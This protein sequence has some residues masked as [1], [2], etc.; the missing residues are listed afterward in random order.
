MKNLL[1]SICSILLFS[2]GCRKTEV[3]NECDKTLDQYDLGNIALEFMPYSADTKCVIFSDSL[4]NEF[5]ANINSYEDS[6]I[7]FIDQGNDA[8]FPD[9]VYHFEARSISVYMTMNL[10][11]P[12]IAINFKIIALPQ[13]TTN[14]EGPI[15]D[16]LWLNITNFFRDPK[17]STALI[18]D[19]RSDETAAAST[20]DFNEITVH[21]KLFKNVFVED[22][23]HSDYKIYLTKEEGLVAFENMDKSISLKLERIE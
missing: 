18:I 3:I 11:N 10:I 9:K 15:R 12:G 5:E 1:I 20:P 19:K 2:L 16:E 14:P 17:G 4:G 6:Y 23:T 8:C 13:S 22:F 7:K 21:D